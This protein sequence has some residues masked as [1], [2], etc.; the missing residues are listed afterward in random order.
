MINLTPYKELNSGDKSIFDFIDVS[1]KIK[2]NVIDY[3]KTENAYLMSPGIYS[4]PFKPE[5]QL[6]GP[7]TYTDG[8]Y[9]WDRDTWKYVVKYGLILPDYFIEHVNS[10]EGQHF[11]S[12]YANQH[13]TWKDLIVNAKRHSDGNSLILLPDDIGDIDLADF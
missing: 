4:H 8:K 6:L 11:Y 9:Y 3:L 7:Y 13:S 12:N 5:I 10:T 1:Q 2:K